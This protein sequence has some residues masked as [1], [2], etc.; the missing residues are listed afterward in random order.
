MREASWNDC[1]EAHSVKKMSPDIER[2][3]S[4]IK[5]SEERIS[6]IDRIHEKNCNFV[7]EDYYTSML[8]LLQ[9]LVIKKGYS[10]LNH[11]CLGYYLRDVLKKEDVFR[12]FDDVKYKRNA[13]TYYGNRMDF[14]TAKAS[15][16]QCK[17]LINKIKVSLNIG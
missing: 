14:E 17:E 11:L 16:E 2:A 5:T 12:I 15:I 10:V 9:A 4:L 7:F 8:E 6:V 1:V 13:L 3:D